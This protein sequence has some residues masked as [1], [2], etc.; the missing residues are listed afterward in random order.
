MRTFAAFYTVVLRCAPAEFRRRYGAEALGLASARVRAAPTAARRVIVAGREIA[1]LVRVCAHERLVSAG[2]AD[3]RRG[4]V[5]PG[6][7]GLRQDVS[8]ATRQLRRQPLPSATAILTLAV[9]IAAATTIFSVLAAVVLRPLPF[10]NADEL[11]LIR[12]AQ[13]GRSLAALSAPE[14]RDLQR[15]AGSLAAV[16]GMW[17]TNG[18]LAIGSD[19]AP[20]HLAWVTSTFFSVLG[21]DPILGRHFSSD[22]DD[23][24]GPRSVII[25]HSLWLRYFNGDR[26]VIGRTIRLDDQPRTVVGVMP[27]GFA[28]Y[29]GNITLAWNRFDL[30]IPNADWPN[31]E[32]R[33]LRTVGRLRA[34]VTLAA[35]N[36]ELETVARSWAESGGAR[37]AA[38]R[39]VATELRSELLGSAGTAL[40]LLAGAVSCVVVIACVNAGAVLRTRAITRR[41]E[42]AI[43]V[44]LGASRLR[45]LRLVLVE[46]LLLAVLAGVAGVSLAWLAVRGLLSRAPAVPRFDEVAIDAGVLA[47][48]L[49]ITLLT[50]LTFAAAPALQARSAATF[51]ALRAGA[52]AVD[53]RRWRA[54]KGVAVGSI[55][56]AVALL[57]GAGLLL[58][59]LGA[60]LAADTGFVREHVLTF[61]ASLSP[62][63][64]VARGRATGQRNILRLAADTY[65]QFRDRVR[66]LPGVAAVGAA[67]LLPFGEGQQSG[68]YEGS[69]A[70]GRSVTGAADYRVVLGGYFD[71][72]GATIVAGRGF[73]DGDVLGAE[74]RVVID[75]SLAERV[76]PDVDPI[77]RTLRVAVDS[78][79]VRMVEAMVIGVIESI[80]AHRIQEPGLPQVYLPYGQYH[81][82]LMDLHFV[83]RADRDP[84]GLVPAVRQLFADAAPERPLARVSTLD[85]DVSRAFSDVRFASFAL[86]AFGAAAIVIAVAGLYGVLSFLAAARVRE[87]GCR[88]A[89]G[90]SRRDVLH[91]FLR[92]GL[93]LG[94]VGL[95]LGLG[96]AAA[97]TAILERLLFRVSPL[98][99]L[100]FAAVAIASLVTILVASLIPA[101]RAARVDAA[102]IL[103]AD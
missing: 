62:A 42:L 17:E 1:D 82:R 59:T 65:Q 36:A 74:R 52:A 11:V 19:V 93:A 99:P 83:V 94:L 51:E 22:E 31:R 47:A 96:A 8:L 9:S 15:H 60:I 61:R 80:R 35:A 95:A 13:E 20:V 76:W 43:R 46:G 57:V 16:G 25:S 55:A 86:S 102:A 23:Q 34:G 88:I 49:G 14:W 26:E 32:M 100:T 29:E 24:R 79:N 89:L 70:D 103:R 2:A 68:P 101:R 54:L 78:N 66:D 90:A 7:D 73:E 77:G 6:L 81:D 85:R 18:T 64:L 12:A 75:R 33:F 37:S 87:V 53:R 98:D 69:T 50:A 48:A 28:H 4:R 5:V 39:L 10:R 97:L 38:P 71:A 21:V 56:L 63:A 30:W 67:Q 3:P 92:E 40:V 41:R 58:R 84:L 45:I 91:L 27:A 72:I 44:A